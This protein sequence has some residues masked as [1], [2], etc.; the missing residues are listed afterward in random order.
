M[1]GVWRVVMRV[2]GDCASELTSRYYSL[3]RFI[4]TW[5]VWIES[6]HRDVDKTLSSEKV[7]CK[8][9]LIAKWMSCK[10]NVNCCHRVNYEW[11]FGACGEQ[12]ICTVICNKMWTVIVVTTSRSESTV[13]KNDSEF[14]VIRRPTRWNVGTGIGLECDW[15]RGV[16]GVRRET[17]NGEEGD[18]SELSHSG[19]ESTNVSTIR[20]VRIFSVATQAGT[21][22]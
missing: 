7:R 6:C 5:I 16:S 15:E 13:W 4:E 17:G 9:L 20:F 21:M 18:R 3:D 14:L 12:Q 11:C 8:Q 19:N 22:K 2:I 10:R 1:T